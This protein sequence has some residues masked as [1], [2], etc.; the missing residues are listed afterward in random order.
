MIIKC[1]FKNKNGDFNTARTYSYLIDTVANPEL[2]SVAVG[3]LL[4]VN[5]AKGEATVQCVA[6]GITPEECGFPVEKLAKIV[7][8]KEVDDD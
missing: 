1:A 7:G 4:V 5:T 3:D 2:A 6:V 8:R